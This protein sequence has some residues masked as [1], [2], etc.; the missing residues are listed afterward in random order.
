MKCRAC[1][2]QLLSQLQPTEEEPELIRFQ[3]T[4][5]N[6]INRNTYLLVPEDELRR[7]VLASLEL[8]A[9]DAMPVVRG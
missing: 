9:R 6:N 8:Q 1:R 5:C 2:S 7:L 3:C 4:G